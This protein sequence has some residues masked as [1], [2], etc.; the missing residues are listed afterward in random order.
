ME[1]GTIYSKRALEGNGPQRTFIGTQ[2]ALD[3]TTLIQESAVVPSG[4]GPSRP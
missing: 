1:V 4:P 2:V 3:Q